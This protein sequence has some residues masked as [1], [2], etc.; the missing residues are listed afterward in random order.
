MPVGGAAL[1]TAVATVLSKVCVCGC[2]TPRACPVATPAPSTRV[3]SV[4]R[5]VH[6][7]STPS[8]GT[9]QSCVVLQ[10]RLLPV[11]SK[12][13][14]AKLAGAGSETQRAFDVE[15]SRAAEELKAHNLR[16]ATER[17]QV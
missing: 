10:R 9:H 12:V 16:L 11:Q 7:S 6:P 13:P 14:F 3:G 4:R 2:G 5:H 15:A 17:C 8:M 1:D